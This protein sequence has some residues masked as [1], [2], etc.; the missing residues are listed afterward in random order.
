[1]VFQKSKNNDA[2]LTMKISKQD[3]ERLKIFADKMNLPVS[4]LIRMAVNDFEKKYMK[5]LEE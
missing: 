1:M 3:R 2:L 4:I 5:E